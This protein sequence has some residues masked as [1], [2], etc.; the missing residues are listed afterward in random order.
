VLNAPDPNSWF[1]VKLVIDNGSIKAFLNNNPDPVL[2]VQS[3]SKLT[4]G[5]VGFWVGNGSKGSF[6]NLVIKAS[7]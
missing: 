5:K 7:Q 2:Q 3:L 1:H 6:S 4:G